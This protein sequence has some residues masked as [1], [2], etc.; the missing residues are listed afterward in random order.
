M[1]F[2]VA[3]PLLLQTRNVPGV[4]SAPDPKQV[5]RAPAPGYADTVNAPLRRFSRQ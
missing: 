2:L 3:L 1:P 5:E 4:L